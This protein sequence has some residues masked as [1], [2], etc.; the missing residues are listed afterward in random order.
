MIEKLIK[1]MTLKEKI[2]QLVQFGK[3]KEEQLKLLKNG[4]IG[5]FLNVYSPKKINELQNNIMNSKN[6]IPLLIGDDVIHGYKT[7]FPI[8]LALSCSWNLELI[9]KTCEI[10]A[11]EAAAD[12]I[13]MIFAP[14]VDISY[15][16]R[17][18][19]VAEGN[20]EDPYLGTEITKVRVR[21]LQKNNWDDL[22]HVT[23]CVKHYVG[24]GA[25]EGGRDYN[26]VDVSERKLREIYLKPFIGAIEENVGSLM[27]SFNEFNGIPPS[28]NTY[29]TKK[30]LREELNFNG[31]VV[32]DWESIKETI[33]HGVS[34]DEKEAALKALLSTV[35]IDMN[36]AV[37]L[38]NLE[39]II[40]E[41]PEL[42][43]LIDD[44][45]L[46]IL[47]LKEK[48]NLFEKHI[49]PE[50]NAKEFRK[51]EYV[52]IARKAALESIVLLKNENNI[53]PLKGINKIA[54]IG[55]LA[56]DNHS[57]LGCWS[58]KGEESNV[59]TVLSAFQNNTEYEIMYEKGCDIFKYN[60][61]EAN[62]ALN[63]A[64]KSDVVVAV[65]GETKE[66]S[67][68][69]NNRSN[70]ELPVAQ[71]RLLKK[72][73]KVNPNIVLVLLNGRPLTLEWED[74]NIPAIVEAW[75]L[76]DESGNA[77]VD[78]LTGKYNPSG[79]LTM[80]FPRK[81]GQIPIYYNHKNTGRPYVRN[82]LDTKNT[83]LYPFGYGLSYTNFEYSNFQ[84]EKQEDIIKLKVDITNTG[85][86]LGEEICQIYFRD[87]YARVSR[88]VKELIRFKKINLN[89][90]ETKTISFEIHISEL[91]YLDENLNLTIDNGSIEFFAG[92]NSQKLLKQSIEI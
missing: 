67:G 18:G 3:L 7:I 27:V 38:N 87:V 70:I 54:L 5:S 55:P 26:S 41:N 53:L 85:K 83:P 63:I 92:T 65:L 77:I 82:Y 43:N 32:S 45:V 74:R 29:L 9:E 46:R 75:H 47:K 61:E 35:D 58:C 42:E 11:R 86:V 13:N 59:V 81:I 56:N 69:N 89:P 66:M 40:K 68:E 49:I 28:A 91:Y 14:M 76:G 51:P 52:N 60:E 50:N 2:G 15:D 36:S 17:W 30:I 34:K 19:R 64:S 72:L 57:P 4:E 84:V 31:V 16:P 88:P 22:P 37:Y 12:G 71:K 6:P 25:V 39:N 33:L 79:K 48:L 1:K 90:G 21:G 20:G 8:P 23:A 80:T 24:Y 73:K 10:T 78:I 62:K 44:A